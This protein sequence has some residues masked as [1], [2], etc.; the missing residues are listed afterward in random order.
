MGPRQ[1]ALDLTPAPA[2]LPPVQDQ[3]VP[4]RE[5]R[6]LSEASM[7][8]EVAL[9][10]EGPISNRG[11]ALMFPP[12]SAWRTRLSDVRLWLQK[13]GET[14]ASYDCGGG[15]WWYWIAEAVR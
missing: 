7:R 9:R 6:R 13:Q 12:G 2:P 10:L 5:M 4:K 11:L 8:I 1:A 3:R 14:V 15:L